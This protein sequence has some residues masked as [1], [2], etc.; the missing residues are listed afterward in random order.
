MDVATFEKIKGKIET[1][2]AKRAKAEGAI[3]S[4]QALWK[5]QFDISTKEELEAL[6]A[7]AEDNCE[8]FEGK[9]TTIMEEL[10]GLTNWS[11]A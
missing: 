9:M 5:K 2:K 3:E 8:T 1:L 4:E 11:L 10:K 6:L 7:E